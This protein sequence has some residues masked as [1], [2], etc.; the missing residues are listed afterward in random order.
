MSTGSHLNSLHGHLQ[1]DKKWQ[2]PIGDFLC[3][4]I[5]YLNKAH[6]E[7]LPK[8][9]KAANQ[10][11]KVSNDILEIY[12][13]HV[14]IDLDVALSRP[15]NV[16][17]A[18]SPGTSPPGAP[19]YPPGLFQSMEEARGQVRAQPIISCLDGPSVVELDSRYKNSAYDWLTRRPGET[20][21]DTL[22]KA[23]D[24]WGQE[25]FLDLVAMDPDAAMFFAQSLN[26]LRDQ[27]QEWDKKLLQSTV[28]KHQPKTAPSRTIGTA[29]QLS[30]TLIS[31]ASS[32]QISPAGST[33]EPQQAQ[34]TWAKVAAIPAT[35]AERT[36]HGPTINFTTSLKDLTPEEFEELVAPMCT[37][38]NPSEAV[39]KQ[40]RVV[41]IR[42]CKKGTQLKDI[43][44]H[45]TEGA[46]MSIFIEEDPSYPPLSACIIFMD[47]EHAAEFMGKNA[48]EI[49]RSG[50]AL[51]GKEIVPG[52]PWAED[53]EIRSMAPPRRERRRLT[54]SCS[55]L[56]QR[57]SRDQFKADIEAIAGAAQ[58]ELIW[59]FNVGNATVV[60]AS[61]RADSRGGVKSFPS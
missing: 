29:T 6:A 20:L 39:R 4:A 7:L 35:S 23:F 1:G 16:S 37:N 25:R 40:G 2:G 30:T 9:R 60:F 43:T 51:C 47:Y 24:P 56:F 17:L 31:N 26:K 27:M 53:D 8:S 54:F 45:I 58:V 22:E 44:A 33:W 57:I 13:T 34:F 41:Y 42:G 19:I 18:S 5:V 10:L 3:K 32:T 55:G 52:G 46:V 12:N 38:P 61:V 11:A 21:A 15:S 28:F 59:L 48:R 36:V 49:G 14:M 50:K